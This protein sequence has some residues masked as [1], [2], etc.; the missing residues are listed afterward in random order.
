MKRFTFVIVLF[1][2]SLLGYGQEI[3]F[4]VLVPDMEQGFTLSQSDMLQR[5]LESLCSRNGA[6]VMNNP[7][8][9]FLYP[10]IAVISD[11]VAES[12]MQNVYSI[13]AELTIS[14]RQI[15]G[16]VVASVSKTYRGVGRSR[17]QAMTAL[18]QAINIS[19][20]EY[21]KFI[22]EAKAAAVKYYQ[23]QCGRIMAQAEQYAATNDYRA[24]IATLFQVP[25]EASCYSIV[26]TKLSEYYKQYQTLLCSTVKMDVEAAMA[27]HNYDGAAL[28]LTEIDPSSECY[29]YAVEQFKQ[30][31]NEVAKIEKRDW[32]FKM[33]QYN[34]AVALEKR[35]IEATTEVAKAYYSTRPAVHYTQVIR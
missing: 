15:D 27:T 11:E 26:G 12:G 24:A 3:T 21:A 2:M 32:D 35:L 4:G 6:F 8:G 9:F 29:N 17:V 31:E 25:Q 18:I 1:A 30:I 19:D 33:K 13:K 34:D 20:A 7:N 10:T 5:R 16:G 23:T 28:L 22:I 14:A